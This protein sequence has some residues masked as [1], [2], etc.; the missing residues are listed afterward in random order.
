M[1]DVRLEGVRVAELESLDF[2]GIL[3]DTE[4]I[5]QS[6]LNIADKTRSNLFPWNGQFSPQ[7][8]EVLLQTYSRKGGLILDPFVGSGTVLSEAGRLGL[9]AVGVEINPA[10]CKMAQTYQFINVP[11][12][13]RKLLLGQAGN[14]LGRLLS[15]AEPYQLNGHT[16]CWSDD[17][18]QALVNLYLKQ[19]EEQ[20]RAILETLI[21]LLD[22]YKNDL[23]RAKLW[24]T[25]IKLKDG[26]I[27]LPYSE[28]PIVL[29]N[30]DA[31][32]LPF[33]NGEVSYVL[34]SPPYI[35]V[36]NY[37]Q[38]Y[39]KSA[40]AMGWNL[41]EVAKS[42]IG[43]NRKN[44]GNRFLTVIQYCLDMAEVFREI[45]RVC[46]EDARI[47]FVMGRESNVRKT[48]FFNGEI[49]A[50]LAT[51]C[52]GFSLTGR[53]ERSFQNRFGMIIYEDLLH[54]LP[55]K[56]GRNSIEA[57]VAFAKD[58]LMKA[59]KRTPQESREDLEEALKHADAV[60]CSAIYNASEAITDKIMGRTGSM[61]S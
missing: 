11:I 48:R 29:A 28:A 21:V 8:V 50:G 1:S 24:S 18:K 54:F 31:R 57:P 47:T 38:Q 4:S 52:T 51:R 39:R 55:D 14:I 35:N 2:N 26:I 23:S 46:K 61:A 44:R 59:K 33:Q 36:F 27:S 34:T 3:L 20:L 49:V 15:E 10:A 12:P 37:H 9:P 5:P 19:S 22:F 58:V 60:A 13:K 41:L 30:C 16:A 25:W 42:E 45:R 6:R 43:S 56:L 32:S 17:I 40:E 53:Q 7:L